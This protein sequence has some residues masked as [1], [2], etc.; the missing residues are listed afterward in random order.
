MAKYLIRKD[1]ETNQ[2]VYMEYDLHGY[3]FNPKKKNNNAYIEVNEVTI[4]N[5]T[6]IDAILTTK[7]NRTFKKLVVM[8]KRVIEE[9]E[10]ATDDEI[11]ICLDEVELVR[12]ILVSKYES[13]LNHE[14][15]QLFLKKLRLIENELRVKQILIKEKA[16][17][18]QEQ[19]ELEHHHTR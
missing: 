1:K 14:K 12:Q 16:L 19:E 11:A 15:E 7:F 17:F 8:A 6:M 2:I 10:D 3:K 13:F 5:K 18:L 4:Y 9:D